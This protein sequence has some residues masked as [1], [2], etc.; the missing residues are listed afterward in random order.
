MTN[1]ENNPFAGLPISL[2]KDILEKSGHIANDIY[3]PFREITNN[4]DKFREQLKQHDIINGD[5]S[6]EGLEI[7]TS[8]CIDGYHTVEKFLTA[9]LS[10]SA[11]FAVEGLVPPSGEKH[12]EQPSHQALFHIEKKTAY[13]VQILQGKLLEK[14]S[15]QQ[16]NLDCL[17][18]EG[19]LHPIPI[20]PSPPQNFRQMWL[21]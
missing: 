20:R 4:R 9:D 2:V 15:T 16:G 5:S 1:S 13:T 18:L 11:A 21:G 7:A 8:C 12:W 17:G 10:C 14:C 3:E 19:H 6:D